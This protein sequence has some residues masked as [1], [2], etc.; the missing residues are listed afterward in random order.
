[1]NCECRLIAALGMGFGNAAL[2]V[3]SSMGNRWKLAVKKRC[4]EQ[5]NGLESVKKKA[6]RIS[7]SYCLIY[8]HFSL[9]TVRPDRAVRAV[10]G[11]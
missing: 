11:S 1:M 7:S 3:I 5:R 2:N 10:S 4:A 6:L 8:L 9:Y